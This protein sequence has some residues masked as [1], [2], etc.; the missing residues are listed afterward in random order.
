MEIKKIVQG[1]FNDLQSDSRCD[2]DVTP[3][4]CFSTK[5]TWERDK[6]LP[7]YPRPKKASRG[8]LAI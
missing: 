8:T 5:Y 3:M 4:G 2:L 7:C 6:N 1:I